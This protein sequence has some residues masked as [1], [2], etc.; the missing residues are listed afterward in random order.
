MECLAF[1]ADEKYAGQRGADTTKSSGFFCHY[2]QRKKNQIFKNTFK[3][4]NMRSKEIQKNKKDLLKQSETL[5][6]QT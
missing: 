2:I 5:P 1:R 3:K 4:E 6:Q